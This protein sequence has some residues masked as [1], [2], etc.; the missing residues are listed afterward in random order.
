[1]PFPRIRKLPCGISNL[2]GDN[3]QLPKLTY[4]NPSSCHPYIYIRSIER[5][6]NAC[7]MNHLSIFNRLTKTMRVIKVS[8]DHLHPTCGFYRGI[9]DARI[10]H[11]QDRLWFI[12]TSTHIAGSYHSQMLLGRFNHAVSDVEFV[13]FLDFGTKPM[14]NVCPFIHDGKLLA[15]DTFMLRVYEIVCEKDEHDA[16]TYRAVLYKELAPCANL[17]KGMMRGSTCPIHLHGNL[18]GCVVHEHIRQARER[19][20]SL[21]YISYWIEFDIERGAVTLLSSPFVV[22]QWGIEFVSGIEYY[23]DKD[24]VELFLGINDKVAVMAK[25]NLHD[26]RVGQ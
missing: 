2:L 18:W 9:E 10:F 7:E 4:F 14:K 6:G 16:E 25:T 15:I 26:L 5:V 23:K 11:Y 20:M 22:A 21:A 24:E 8:L 19:V 1:M 12:A 13:Q 17:A 3:P